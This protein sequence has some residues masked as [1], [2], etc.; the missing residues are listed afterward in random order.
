[1]GYLLLRFAV[2]LIVLQVGTV[3]PSTVC[4]KPKQ[5]PANFR[6][7]YRCEEGATCCVHHG[8]PGCCYEEPP[9]HHHY[10]TNTLLKLT[11][12]LA[13]QGSLNG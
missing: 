7:I 13:E 3:M 8:Q 6:N 9:P 10:Y 11:K 2:V 1:M 5:G 4:T 12:R